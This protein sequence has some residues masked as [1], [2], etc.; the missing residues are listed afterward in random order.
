MGGLGEPS[1]VIFYLNSFF[2]VS[3]CLILSKLGVSDTRGWG[4]KVSERSLN[5]Y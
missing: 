3:L 1:S 2:S 4:Y 5:V